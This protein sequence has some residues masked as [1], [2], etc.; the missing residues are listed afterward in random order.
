MTSIAKAPPSIMFHHFCDDYHPQGQGAITATELEALILWV[1]RENVLSASQW[2]AHMEQGTLAPSKIC[3]TFDDNLRCQYD[4][5]LPVLEKFGLTAF[6]FVYTGHWADKIIPRLEVYRYF[7]TVYYPDIEIFYADFFK[8]AE[9]LHGSV[10]RKW[11]LA[12]DRN[13]FSDYVYPPYYSLNDCRFREMR[14][15]LMTNDQYVSVMDEL[16]CQ[17]DVSVMET[18]HR[19]MMSPQ[20]VQTLSEKGHFIGLHSHTHPTNM[21]SLPAN[22]QRSQY[23][24]NVA[25][26]TRVTGQIPFCISHP[27]NSYSIETLNILKDLGIKFGFR[28]NVEQ[29]NYSKYEIPRIDHSTL[30]RKMYK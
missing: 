12:F 21:A 14:D 10:I 25:E 8:V 7:R 19:T 11:L 29:K 20:D 18:I 27:S 22:E 23:E 9:N 15:T 3:L 30:M 24:K 17:K 6:W 2:Q 28:A 26:I 1:G 4:I 16:L 13:Q 5:A